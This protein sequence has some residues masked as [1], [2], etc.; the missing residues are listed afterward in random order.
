MKFVRLLNLFK[1]FHKLLH[2]HELERST[3]QKEKV[4]IQIEV[5]VKLQKSKINN[6]KVSIIIKR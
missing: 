1:L 6:Q 3:L 4:K 5:N 2:L